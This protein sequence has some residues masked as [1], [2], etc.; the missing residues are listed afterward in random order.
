MKRK[1]RLL[2]STKKSNNAIEPNLRVVNLARLAISQHF[3][4]PALINETRADA[5]SSST[6][7]FIDILV[8][9]PQLVVESEP[10]IVEHMPVQ[11]LLDI[12][13]QSI[14]ERMLP[15]DLL[16]EFQRSP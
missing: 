16:L 11:S 5:P 10:H 13:A 14:A 15:L 7:A 6:N 2:G 12:L 4:H 3:E 8:A 1:S 9:G